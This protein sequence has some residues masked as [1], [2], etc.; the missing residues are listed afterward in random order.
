M[1]IMYIMSNSK[2]TPPPP[3]KNSP[4]EELKLRGYRVWIC[5]GKGGYQ[6]PQNPKF[7]LNPDKLKI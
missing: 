2:L 5:E 4:S 7:N 6:N 1:L 3:T